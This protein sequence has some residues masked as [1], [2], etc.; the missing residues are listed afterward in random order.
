MSAGSA[1][2]A[3][4][5]LTCPQLRAMKGAT[6]IV[7]ITAYDAVSGKLV[8]P[9]ADLVLV[10]DSLGPNVLGYDSTIPVTLDEMIAAGRAVSRGSQ[11]ALLVGDLPFGTYQASPEDAVRSSARFIKE[12]GMQAVKLEGGAERANAIA[13]VVDAGIPV[14]AHIGLLPQSVHAMGGYRVQGKTEQGARDLLEDAKAVAAAGAFALVL[15]GIPD[16]V[17]AAITT[18]VD[19]PTIGIGAGAS[20]D[21]QI[22][23]FTDVMGLNFGHLPKFVRPYANLREVAVEGLAKYRDEVRNGKFPSSAESYGG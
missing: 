17:A 13:A 18:A 20:C 1:A 19:I 4:K 14:V 10:G 16:S 3:P 21:G 8:D 6:K 7:A 5:R 23:V 9:I 2:Q 22:L 11:R 12:A 15:E